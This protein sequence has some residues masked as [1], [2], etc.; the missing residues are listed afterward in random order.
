MDRLLLIWSNDPR[1]S[2]LNE[3][4]L[5]PTRSSNQL[6]LTKQITPTRQFDLIG[7]SSTR[8]HQLC[9]LPN[10]KSAPTD[11]IQIDERKPISSS[12]VK[13][14]MTIKELETMDRFDNCKATRW[15]KYHWRLNKVWIELDQ[16]PTEE[17]VCALSPVQS[18]QRLIDLTEQS[19]FDWN[20]WSWD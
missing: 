15:N 10:C 16:T 4:Q 9:S 13:H 3:S 18:T 12:R 8:E 17:V 14:L 1:W 2:Q 6:T 5:Q 20:G 7:M 19:Q 11:W